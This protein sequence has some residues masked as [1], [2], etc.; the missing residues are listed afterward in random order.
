[1]L[2]KIRNRNFLRILFFKLVIE[3]K[4]LNILKYNKGLQTKLNLSLENYKKYN[5]IK[6][7]VIPIENLKEKDEE[8]IFI[9]TVENESLYHIYFNE[10]NE[11]IERKYIKNNEKISKIIILIDIEVESL[12]DLFYGC[13]S[14]KEIKFISFNR[15][16]IIDMGY[17]FAKCSNLINLDIS[18]I[19][20]DNVTH[21]EYMFN[22]CS[23]LENL[24]LS[25]FKTD[26]VE[27]MNDMFSFC[28]NLSELN[29][30][31]F[32]IDC[33][34]N[35]NSMFS[36]CY[37]LKELNISSFKTEQVEDMSQMFY[38]CHSLQD[39]DISNLNINE[40]VNVKIKSD[41]SPLLISQKNINAIFYGCSEDLELKIR[42]QKPDVNEKVFN[43]E[44]IFDTKETPHFVF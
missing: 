29:L 32:K 4:Y 33:V 39:L 13:E 34:K 16:N 27:Y 19:K 5:Q 2:H 9:N 31:N 10:S 12:R 38:E 11:E 1:M 18:K 41:K 22:E 14:I 23:K 3:A 42:K 35:M 40:Y 44:A 28:T 26:K 15:K 24:N 8:N 25:N 30:S 21:M 43:K 17:M 20:T 37:N 7:E 36:A 6:I